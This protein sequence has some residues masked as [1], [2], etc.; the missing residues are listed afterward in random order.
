MTVNLN[1]FGKALCQYIVE[2]KKEWSVKPKP[3][4]YIRRSQGHSRVVGRGL[5]EWIK[6]RA[7]YYNA[8]HVLETIEK[9]NMR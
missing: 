5:D 8:L 6:Q 9:R 1:P 3:P 2:A 7:I 4:T